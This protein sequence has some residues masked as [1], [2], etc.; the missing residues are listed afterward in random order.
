LALIL[1][2]AQVS[3]C[4]L[5]RRRLPPRP[6][7]RCCGPTGPGQLPCT[8]GAAQASDLPCLGAYVRRA[9]RV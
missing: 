7:R 4:A 6:A 8:S 9:A 5:A 1:P 2:S 3:A